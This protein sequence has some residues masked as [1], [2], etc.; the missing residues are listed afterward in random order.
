MKIA[1]KFR[2]QNNEA[3]SITRTSV[4]LRSFWT[5]ETFYPKFGC[6]ADFEWNM[7]T[8]F[9]RNTR[10]VM[11][12]FLFLG[13]QIERRLNLHFDFDILEVSQNYRKLR[14]LKAIAKQQFLLNFCRWAESTTKH[15][16]SQSQCT[17]A[18]LGWNNGC[19]SM[20]P[21]PPGTRTSRDQPM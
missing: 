7:I 12:I 17:S 5:H 18:W 21:T 2:Y 20:R 3:K 10:I 4:I 1:K 16:M 8:P 19:G 14:L 15:S 9:D 13:K 11:S 6:N